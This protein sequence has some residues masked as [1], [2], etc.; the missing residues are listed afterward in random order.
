MNTQQNFDVIVIGGGAAGLSA[1]TALGRSRRSVL[2]IDAGRPRNLP[3]AGVHNILSRDGIAPTDL[4]AMGRVEVE[5]YGGT[6]IAGEAVAATGSAGDFTVTLADGAVYGARRLVLTT[7]LVDR[8]PEIPGLREHWGSQVLHC[9]YCHGWEVQGQPIGI[10]ATGPMAAHQA[11]LFR[12]LTDDLTYFTHTGPDLTPE[13]SELFAARDITVVS[14]LVEAVISDNGRLTGVRLADGS[15]VLRSAL[16]IAPQ[17]FLASS[18]V[19]QLGLVAQPHQM[20]EHIPSE[21]AGGTTVPGVRVAGSLTNPGDQVMA[22]AAG[23]VMAGAMTNF[24]LIEED[25]AAALLAHRGA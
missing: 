21:M 18:V 24:D 16:V 23:G 7:G 25:N 19:T 6:V 17:L 20:G 8:L 15:Q 22:A 3:A 12:Q 14:G 1:A 9:P 2:V 13:Q 5:S 4:T 10:L 11:M